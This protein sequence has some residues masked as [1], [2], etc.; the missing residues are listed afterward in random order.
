MDLTPREND[1]AARVAS[2]WTNKEI[3]SDLGI[4][5]D[6]VKKHVSH[7]LRK[8]ELP[9]RAALAAW[10]AVREVAQAGGQHERGGS[11]GS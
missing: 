10:W 7:I 6:Q 3:A 9:N 4:G 8:L 2:G 5:V 11:E 1:V